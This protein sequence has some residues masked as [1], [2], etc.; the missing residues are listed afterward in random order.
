MT[1]LPGVKVDAIYRRLTCGGN[2]GAQRS[3][4][5]D[6]ILFHRLCFDYFDPVI[7]AFVEC[8]GVDVRESS[9]F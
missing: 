5:G 9:I 2:A 6:N 3:S 1:R 7:P 8:F 4:I